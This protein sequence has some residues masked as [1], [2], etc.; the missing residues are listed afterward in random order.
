MSLRIECTMK[1]YTDL[2]SKKL[3]LTPMQIR[4]P[5]SRYLDGLLERLEP[6]RFKFCEQIL[7]LGKWDRLQT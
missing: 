5:R 7:H 6:I 3:P 4:R 2:A 1:I